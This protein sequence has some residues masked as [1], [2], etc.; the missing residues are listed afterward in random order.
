LWA[1]REFVARSVVS[2]HRK[3]GNCASPEILIHLAALN[4]G[5]QTGPY[6]ITATLGARAGE[7]FRARDP[8]LNRDVVGKVLPKVLVVKVVHE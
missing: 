3:R 1:N 6:E 8:R 4:A 7:V 5:T 2:P